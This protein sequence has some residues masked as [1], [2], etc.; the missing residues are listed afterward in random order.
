MAAAQKQDLEI[1]AYCT[2]SSKLQL[3]DIPFGTE[4]TTLLC[5]M[6]TGLARPIVPTNWRHP[7]F[8]C[9]TQPVPPLC[10]INKK[11]CCSKVCMEWAAK[12]GRSLG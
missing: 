12:A 2:A 1:Q 7:G 4:E 3:E 8:H 10:V 11:A 6:S 5:D 9:D